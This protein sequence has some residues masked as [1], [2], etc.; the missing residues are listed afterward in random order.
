LNHER[1]RSKAA[2]ECRAKASH[3]GF[4]GIVRFK[5]VQT[6]R[7]RITVPRQ[8][9]PP[10]VTKD[11]TAVAVEVQ[12]AYRA[13]FPEGDASFVP[14]VFGWT[15]DCFTGQYKDYLPIDAPYHDFEHTL[16]GVL[17]MARLL[18]GW[19]WAGTEPHLTQEIV[20][21]GLIAILFHDSGYL[22]QRGDVEGT[23]AKYTITHVRRS[24][25]F[26]SEFLKEKGF[27]ADQIKSV[28]NMIQCTGLESAVEAIPFG[29]EVERIVGYALGTAD[30]L[31]QMAADDYVEKLPVLYREFEE[32]ARHA[33]GTM[34]FVATYS[35]AEDLMRRTPS[36]WE[37]FVQAKLTRE[38]EG[39]YRYLNNPYPQG[40]NDYLDRIEANIERLRCI[41]P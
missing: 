9:Y 27:S 15:A 6:C 2:V 28:R 5:G 31:G 40:A 23:G 12:S 1:T 16:Q 39:L 38:F 10:V 26:A 29:S 14:R 21:L 8:M 11:P 35:S 3:L 20:E 7:M 32:A 4:R 17:C 34:H 22:K 25:E 19:H 33:Q 36:F 41:A 18:R 30:L 13:L 24:G 37:N